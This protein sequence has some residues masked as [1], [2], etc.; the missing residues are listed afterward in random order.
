MAECKLFG[1]AHIVAAP[2]A[3]FFLLLRTFAFGRFPNH[4]LTH[5]VDKKGLSPGEQTHQRHSLKSLTHDELLQVELL[6][7][8]G[9]RLAK[10]LR[11]LFDSARAAAA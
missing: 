2:V 8:L 7:D 9:L 10:H 5:L 11:A 1:V 6:Q 3:Q 4:H